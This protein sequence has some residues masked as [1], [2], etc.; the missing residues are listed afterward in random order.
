MVQMFTVKNASLA[1]E[2][3]LERAA[4]KFV[5]N[6]EAQLV[7]KYSAIKTKIDSW[8][9]KFTKGCTNVRSSERTSSQKN[10]SIKR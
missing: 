10:I 6:V 7:I 1:E 8:I 2:D 5:L 3:L 4:V 9:K